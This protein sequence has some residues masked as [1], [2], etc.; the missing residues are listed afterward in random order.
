MPL[1]AIQTGLHPKCRSGKSPGKAAAS[2]VG[3]EAAVPKDRA[4]RIAGDDLGKK[5]RVLP[6]AMRVGKMTPLNQKISEENNIRGAHE[7]TDGNQVLPHSER[8]SELIGGGEL[9]D[10]VEIRCAI[11]RDYGGKN[12]LDIRINAPTARKRFGAALR[13][14]VHGTANLRKCL[15]E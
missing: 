15:I 6:D 10:Y 2:Y 3:F 5:Q 14:G 12:G 8:C 13:I 4:R 9:A 11:R 7:G 1:A